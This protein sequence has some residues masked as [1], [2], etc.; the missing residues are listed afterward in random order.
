[1]YGLVNKAVKDFVIVNHGE[2]TWETIR[3]KAGVEVETFNSLHPYDDSIT[4]NLVGA[5]SEHFSIPAEAILEGFGKFWIELASGKDYKHYF[6]HSGATLPAF[7]KNLDRMHS[8]IAQTYTELKPPSFQCKEVDRENIELKYFSD[9]SG[10]V[11]FVIGL[12]KG[13]SEQFKVISEISVDP[14]GKEE[15]GYELFKIKY[16]AK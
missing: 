15:L 8:N 3:T 4:Y 16:K 7:L 2:D 12:L 10:L 11:P 1:M 5:A 14:R 6:E 9:R 13:L